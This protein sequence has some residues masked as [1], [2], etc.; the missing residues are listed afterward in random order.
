[1]GVGHFEN[2][3]DQ[4]EDTNPEADRAYRMHLEDPEDLE[5]HLDRPSPEAGL[6]EGRQRTCFDFGSQ[7]RL[8]GLEDPEDLGCTDRTG[9]DLDESGPGDSEC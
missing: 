9:H 3:A 5:G 8:E 2:Q 4:G 7:E 1:M 6:A